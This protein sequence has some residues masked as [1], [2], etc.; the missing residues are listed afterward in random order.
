MALALVDRDKE[1]LQKAACLLSLVLASRPSMINTSLYKTA[2]SLRLPKLLDDL[3]MLS[4]CMTHLRLESVDIAR[5]QEGIDHLLALSTRLDTLIKLHNNLQGID[6][7]LR[8]IAVSMAG[9]T[10]PEGARY[11][12]HQKV[13]GRAV[14]V[15]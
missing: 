12:V 7:E 3:N 6:N 13:G 9:D 4:D 15:V 11:G 1:Q 2:D 14:G 10:P 5:F 8:P